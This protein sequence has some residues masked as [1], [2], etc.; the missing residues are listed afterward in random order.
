[1]SEVKDHTSVLVSSSSNDTLPPTNSSKTKEIFAFKTSDLY[2]AGA[3]FIG[4]LFFIFMALTAV[5][6]SL[7]LSE[8]Q[9]Q[10]QKFGADS[11]VLIAASFGLALMSSIAMVGNISGGHL[12]PA[13]TIGLFAIG[14]ISAP[15]AVFYIIAQMIGACVGAAFADL[16][17]AG[18]L[19]GYNAVQTNSNVGS[20]FGAE[21]LMTFVLV[22]VVFKSAVDTKMD[23]GF[24]PVLIGFAVFALHLSGVTIDGTSIN[25]ARSFGAAAVA[26][27]WDNHWIFWVGPI[28]GG[29]LAAGCFTVFNQLKKLSKD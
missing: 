14:E 24:A 12:N 21:V 29:L 22:M 19:F 8:T 18:P 2:K 16:V 3:E 26:G 1:M 13:V 11:I 4:T 7:A 25:P 5:Q 15:A 20:A 6:A 23:S 17:S 10:T 9:V 27:K 28:L